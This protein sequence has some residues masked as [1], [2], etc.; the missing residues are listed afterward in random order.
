[1]ESIVQSCLDARVDERLSRMTPDTCRNWKQ[2]KKLFLGTKSIFLAAAAAVAVAVAAA[3]AAAAAAA[4][5]LLLLE[6]AAAAPSFS[7]FLS[8]EPL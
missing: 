1:M 8:S 4:W 6:A 5:D 7:F 2:K 3:A